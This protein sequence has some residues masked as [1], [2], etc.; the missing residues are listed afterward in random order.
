LNYYLS[1]DYSEKIFSDV[2]QRLQVDDVTA[3]RGNVSNPSVDN[4]RFITYRLME[5]NLA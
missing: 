4:A 5:Y 3:A 1:G 2:A